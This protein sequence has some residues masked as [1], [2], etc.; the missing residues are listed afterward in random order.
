MTKNLQEMFLGTMTA[1]EAAEE[2]QLEQNKR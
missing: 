2:L 1:Q